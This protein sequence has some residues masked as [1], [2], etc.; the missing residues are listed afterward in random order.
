MSLIARFLAIIAL[1]GLALVAS[2]GSQA[3][4]A[5]EALDRAG[6]ARGLNTPAAAL[7]EAAAALAAERGEI[8]GLLA[9]P[10][11]ATAAG[12]D[13]ARARRAAAEAQLAAALPPLRALARPAGA[14]PG[15][16]EALARHDAA[17]ARLASLRQAADASPAGLAAP[18][19]FAAASAQIDAI[20][21]LRRGIEGITEATDLARELVALRDALA[22][23]A[24]YAGRE[25]GLV[26]G[27]IAGGAPPDGAQLALLGSLRG[28]VEGAWARVEA[29]APRLPAPAVAAVAAAAR[30]YFEVFEA[31]RR[32]VLAAA[33]RGTAW[34]IAP[35]AWFAAASEGMA[36]VLAAGRLATDAADAALAEAAAARRATLLGLLA[37]AAAAIALVLAAAWHV[38]AR[39]A[40]P[41]RIAVQALT[42]LDQGDLE[43]PLPAARGIAEVAAL[44]RATGSFLAAARANRAMLAERDALAA[45]AEARRIEALREMADLLEADSGRM[46]ALVERQADAL[47]AESEAMAAGATR[48][49][50]L[51][52][53]AG[54][55][56]EQSRQG[57][58]AAAT[59]AA[60]LPAA[61]GEIARQMAAAAGTTQDAVRRTAA[62]RDS[63]EALSRSVGEITEVT[64]L[65]ADIAGRTNLLALNAT[66]EAAR[67][68]EAGK[69]FAVV[70]T[71]V[72]T[73]AGLTA[74][75]TEDIGRRI[76]GIDASAR[77][78]LASIEGIAAAVQ[79]LDQVAASIGAAT[80]AQS[81]TTAGIVEA[82]AA[83][84]S[85]AQG[86]ARRV[87]EI[88]AAT[89]HYGA[90]AG[91]VRD[92]STALSAEVGAMRH[93]LVELLRTRVE[94]VNRRASERR[95][96]DIPAR[97]IHPGGVLEGRLADLSAGGASLTGIPPAAAAGITAARL[98]APPLAARAVTILGEGDG[99]L[100]LG[101]A[102]PLAETAVSAIAARPVARAA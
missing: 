17:A 51:A 7:V 25:R 67:A 80:D 21:G 60:A 31:T 40:R 41:L 88:R 81:A 3:W 92:R 87:A 19:W 58:D 43:T 94:G 29:L 72:K 30:A 38:Q 59:G 75:S 27:L 83:A 11:A 26:N 2:L 39:V 68:G 86:V 76:A 1:L 6:R 44:L 69:G 22:E 55:L 13:R 70:A 57:V 56:S 71:E 65:I 9:N 33:Q 78:A 82:V 36:A 66:I 102:E 4:Q 77:D 95:P 53:Q 54:G 18:A 93:A 101:F 28:R 8:N 90:A 79:A 14:A 37:L 10:A 62:A 42:R 52:E 23:V 20:F 84:A 46:V 45:A 98:E 47:R 50:A 49:V 100:R 32:P 99:R 48:A 15:L 16:A 12:W 34:P 96:V 73:L 61:I 35:T 97:L 64:R 85:G 5:G 24:E 91:S 63:F 74:Q 89:Q